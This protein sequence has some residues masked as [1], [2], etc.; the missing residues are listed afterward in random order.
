MQDI[1]WTELANYL[2]SLV[3]HIYIKRIYIFCFNYLKLKIMARFQPWIKLLVNHDPGSGKPSKEQ[4]AGHSTDWA[5]QPLIK[6]R[7]VHHIYN[8]LGHFSV[9]Q[10]YIECHHSYIKIFRFSHKSIHNSTTVTLIK[11]TEILFNVQILALQK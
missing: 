2:L 5:T 4:N 6:T 1:L 11:A 10:T 7:L 3:H 8:I 9:D